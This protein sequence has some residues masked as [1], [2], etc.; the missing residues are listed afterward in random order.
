MTAL[1]VDRS[2][3]DTHRWLLRIL[4]L[5]CFAGALAVRLVDLTDLPLDFHPT[6]QLQS[7]LKARGMYYQTLTD[8][9]DWQKQLA[10]SQWHTQPIQ[11]PEV[12]EHLAVFSYE[13]AG[14]EY[15]W[16]PRLYSILFWMIGGIGL[17]T[18]IRAMV[19]TGGAFVGTVFY[20]F[21]Q[22]GAIASR[23]FQPD[24]L[25][26]MFII[27][28]MW[29]LYRWYQ[30]PTWTWTVIAGLLCGLA[31]YIKSPAIFF[32]A[33]GIAGLLIGDRGLKKTVRDPKV[34]LLGFL[35][36]LPALV[37]HI[38]GT[39]ILHFLGSD[40]YNQRLYP[41]LLLNPL[42]YIQVSA[43]IQSVVGFPA[44]LIAL[45]G[46]FLLATRRARSL[47]AGLW[48]GYFLFCAV[49]IYF[50]SSHTYYHLPLILIVAVGIGAVAQVLI[51]H[52][53]AIWVKSWVYA[54]V[55]GLV[56]FYAGQQAYTVRSTLR[57]V[58]YRPEATF[59]QNLGNE[60]RSYSV[61]G[62]TPD[63]GFRMQYWGWDNIENWPTTGDFAKS[64]LTGGQENLAALF[65]D[66]TT[67]KQLFLVTDMTQLD[68]QPA[69]KEI[70]YSDYPVFDQGSGYIIFDLRK[71]LSSV[72]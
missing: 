49:F 48:V 64:A 40:Y 18:L 69:L 56:L 16:I 46:T 53:R 22:F 39:F 17:F 38:L 26:V 66:K 7:M 52:L 15:L 10:I 45:L 27:L 55:I 50:A 6:R 14:A 2:F 9:P 41:E 59:W 20:L 33:G 32:I 4:L 57:S 47:L 44:F 29:A 5:V 23:S 65:A 62:I 1:T 11:E 58:D 51:D 70:L 19:G 8:V 67:G 13:I 25:M 60:L 24:P 42:S 54:L 68:L 3:W 71:S 43:L 63:Y 31:I 12:M 21:S 37:Y 28:G 61:V 36:F 30:N 72:H 34:W 35:A